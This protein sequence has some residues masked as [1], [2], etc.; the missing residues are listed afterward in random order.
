[1]ALQDIIVLI[2]SI[3]DVFLYM[4]DLYFIDPVRVLGS[5]LSEVS[6]SDSWERASELKLAVGV[7]KEI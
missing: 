7:H 3:Y 6:Q 4:E 5:I 1:M 2:T